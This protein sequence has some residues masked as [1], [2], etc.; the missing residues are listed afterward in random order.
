M[1]TRR[2]AGRLCLAETDPAGWPQ[3]P[4][5]LRPELAVR[6]VPPAGARWRK[7]RLRVER[8][9]T[10]YGRFPCSTCIML[11]STN[12][13]SGLSS[14]VS[15]KKRRATSTSM[16]VFLVEIVLE[17]AV[18]VNTR[19]SGDFDLRRLLI[20]KIRVETRQ[21]FLDRE[22]VRVGKSWHCL[23]L[24]LS[25]LYESQ[26]LA[27]L[28]APPQMEWCRHPRMGQALVDR[29]PRSNEPESAPKPA[30][31]CQGMSRRNVTDGPSCVPCTRRLLV[32]HLLLEPLPSSRPR[33]EADRAIAFAFLAR[34]NPGLA[35]STSFLSFD[36]LRRSG[37][38]ST[39]CNSCRSA[40][41]TSK[42]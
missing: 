22:L 12:R 25:S 4:I 24:P 32:R 16:N 2:S 11:V 7:R 1:D 23:G 35:G 3:A 28:Q 5:D 30:S 40:T 34:S 6:S 41:S 29:A 31:S 10:A 33:C 8:R 38:R 39:R 9:L 27:D 13:H 20:L 14:R 15:R 21:G 19:G 18:E 26:T 17:A 42:S 36:S 37:R